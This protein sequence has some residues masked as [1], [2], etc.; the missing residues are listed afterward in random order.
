MAYCSKADSTF[1]MYICS[2]SESGYW[3]SRTSTSTLSAPSLSMTSTTL[4][5]CTP[6]TIT[7]TLPL[8]SLRFWITEATTPTS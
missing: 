8:G 5:R 2:S 3:I 4:P 7:L 6:S 1:P